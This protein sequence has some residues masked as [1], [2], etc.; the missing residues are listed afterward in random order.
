[1][2]MMKFNYYSI[3]LRLT[4]KFFTKKSGC[5]LRGLGVQKD[6]QT[7]CWL[8]PCTTPTG[9]GEIKGKLSKMLISIEF[10]HLCSKKNTMT[11]YKDIMLYFNKSIHIHGCYLNI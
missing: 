7:P 9:A 1:M 3:C 8:R 5:L 6:A 10:F 11:L 2:E 4:K